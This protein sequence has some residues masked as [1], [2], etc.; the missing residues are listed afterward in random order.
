MP[1]LQVWNDLRIQIFPTILTQKILLRIT[2]I[3]QKHEQHVHKKKK[4]IVLVSWI[5]IYI[6]QT[7]Y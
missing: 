1:L 7:F 6:H 3:L 4:K 5:R 2:G